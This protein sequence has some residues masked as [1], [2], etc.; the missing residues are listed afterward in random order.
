L[1]GLIDNYQGNAHW[2]MPTLLNLLNK[3]FGTPGMFLWAG[4]VLFGIALTIYFWVKRTPQTAAIVTLAITPIISPYL[5]SWDFVLL[6]PLLIHLSINGSKSKSIIIL[7]AL[8]LVDTYFWKIRM[9]GPISDFVNWPIPMILLGS[10]VFVQLLDD[11]RSRKNLT[12]S[13]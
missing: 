6:F 12:E 8:I 9:F 1:S 3:S 13:A 4:M 10:I 2:D 11:R 5:W 7:S